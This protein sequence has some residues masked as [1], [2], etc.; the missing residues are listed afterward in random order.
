MQEATRFT[1]VCLQSV[2]PLSLFI[3][4][5]ACAYKAVQRPT[6]MSL[7]SELPTSAQLRHT[8][9]PVFQGNLCFRLRYHTVFMLT[10]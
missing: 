1:L 6:P 2:F 9:I 4:P 7:M 3:R 5:K 10:V 8:N